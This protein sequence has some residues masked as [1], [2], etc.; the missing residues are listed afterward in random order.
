MIGFAAASS[1]ACAMAFLIVTALAFLT[2]GA[3]PP[4]IGPSVSELAMTVLFYAPTVLVVG[5]LHH[6]LVGASRGDV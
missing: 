4:P 5:W 3:L 1:F 2:P 6:K